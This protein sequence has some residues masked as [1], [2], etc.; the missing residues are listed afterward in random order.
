MPQTAQIEMR[1]HVCGFVYT[2]RTRMLFA[3]KFTATRQET[4]KTSTDIVLSQAAR[5]PDV[6]QKDLDECRAALI[7]KFPRRLIYAE[8]DAGLVPIYQPPLQAI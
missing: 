3:P 2:A 7:E 5:W 6:T 1:Y 8:T 4:D